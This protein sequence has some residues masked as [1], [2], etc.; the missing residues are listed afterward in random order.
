MN[1]TLT[2][3][4]QIIYAIIMGVFGLMHFMFGSAM[5]GMVPAFIPGGVFWVYVTGLGLVVAAVSIIS[6]KKTRLAT[7]LLAAML[8]IFVLTIHLPAMLGGDQMAMSSLLKD[9]GLAGCALIIA[10]N[11]ED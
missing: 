9:L 4:G 11:S 8:G 10:G 1:T 5:G 7:L 2:K 3:T 6:G